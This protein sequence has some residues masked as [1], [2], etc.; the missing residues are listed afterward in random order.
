MRSK[1]DQR[2]ADAWSAILWPVG[3]LDE[4]P[5]RS[6]RCCQATK[7]A[8]ATWPVHR[9]EH[10][11]LLD[12]DGERVPFRICGS[13]SPMPV[14]GL[15]QSLANSCS[16]PSAVSATSA[17]GRGRDDQVKRGRR[18]HVREVV[19]LGGVP[20][21]VPGFQKGRFLARGKPCVANGE[22]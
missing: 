9:S 3:A 12:R 14:R 7:H 6:W 1:V 15:P 8:E 18:P 22:W 17:G 5:R 21:G 16:L 13:T 11:W 2:S 19:R 10:R 20:T 4:L